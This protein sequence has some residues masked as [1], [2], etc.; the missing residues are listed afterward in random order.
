MTKGHCLSKH[1]VP[2]WMLRVCGYVSLCASQ[3]C[4]YCN[5]N[6]Y[7]VLGMPYKHQL[8]NSLFSININDPFYFFSVENSNLCFSSAITSGAYSKLH[9]GP[10]MDV[11]VW[12]MSY[13]V[14]WQVLSGYHVLN[15]VQLLRLTSVCSNSHLVEKL[16]Y[17][18]VNLAREQLDKAL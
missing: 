15:S 3:H 13:F 17:V 16:V 8:W 2:K 14:L 6:Y 12:M 4:I 1:I 10:L 7:F 5:V 9:M 18:S 11:C